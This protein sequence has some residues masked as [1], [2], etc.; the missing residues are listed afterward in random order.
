MTVARALVAAVTGTNG[1]TSVVGFTRQLLAAGGVPA[2]SL[3]SVGLTTPL[4]HE[5]DPVLAPGAAELRELAT[6]VQADGARVLVLE[7]HSRALAR[8]ALD[9]LEVDVAAGT[10]LSPD[11]LDVHGDMAAY[12]AAKRRL[13]TERLRGDGVAVLDLAEPVGRRLSQ[14]CADRGVGVVTL[15]GQGAVF[16]G[17]GVSLGRQGGVG[18][19]P[20]GAA[21]A[22]VPAAFAAV[23]F[24]LRNV[25]LALAVSGTILVRLGHAQHLDEAVGALVPFLPG[26][27]LPPGRYQRVARGDGVEV[28]VDHAH[29]PGALT[30]VLAAA[31]AEAS[32]RV[33]LVLGCGGE[34]DRTKRASMGR[35]AAEGADAVLVT[36]DNPRG[37]DPAT[38]RAAVL[39]GA[40]RAPGA[41]LVEEVAD[42]RTAIARAIALAG[43]GDLVVVAGRGDEREQHL[44]DGLRVPLDDRVVAQE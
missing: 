6:D 9:A 1:K 21:A 30:A 33:L 23:P 38:I 18:E 44:V 15:D 34:R 10:N 27:A 28:V 39:D 2:A 40:R 7:A 14:V 41:A 42:R 3:S 29:G 25:W 13:F 19:V 35:I 36:D 11:H 24:L 43:Q 26:L 37:E 17:Q 20:L 32:G 5:A 12:E 22:E 4:R 8:G 31:R 16:G